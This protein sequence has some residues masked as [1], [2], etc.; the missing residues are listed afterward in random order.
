VDG[1]EASTFRRSAFSNRQEAAQGSPA[2]QV[3]G[4]HGD[5]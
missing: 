4:V 2:I 1:E 3:D 5:L